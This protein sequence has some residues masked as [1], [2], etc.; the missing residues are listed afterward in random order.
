MGV[1]E[2]ECSIGS[3]RNQRMNSPAVILRRL[4]GD[5]AA[6]RGERVAHL[7]SGI[8]AQREP[9]GERRAELP[10][11]GLGAVRIICNLQRVR[12]LAANCRG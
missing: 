8:E 1:A 11:V 5:A 10:S 4:L 12:P 2:G 3:L 7:E 6:E 9:G